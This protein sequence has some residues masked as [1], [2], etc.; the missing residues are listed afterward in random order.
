[1]NELMNST[2]RSEGARRRLLASVST[3]VLLVCADTMAQAGEDSHP[4]LWIELGGQLET[5]S[6][7]QDQFAPAFLADPPPLGPRPWSAAMGGFGT[8]THIDPGF[9]NPFEPVHPLSMQKPPNY[10]FGGEGKILLQPQ[11][12]DWVFAASVRY[13]RSNGHKSIQK[14]IPI[15]NYL[16]N[17]KYFETL[18]L[19]NDT[20]T[21][22][23]ESHGVLDFQVGRDV[24]LGLIGRKAHSTVNFGVRIA[25]LATK[26]DVRVDADP[27]MQAYKHV[28]GANYTKYDLR[29]QTYV[30]HGHSDRSFHGIGPSLS[31]NGSAP[32]IGNP[33]TMEFALDWGLNG[34]VLFGR[35]KADVSHHT[36]H[37]DRGGAQFGNGYR[38]NILIYN[39]IE[40]SDRA[41]SVIVP[42]VGAFAGLSAKFP[43][44]QV[45]FGY[46]ADFFFGAMDTGIDM[47]HTQ[48]MSFHGPFAKISIGLG[49]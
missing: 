19:F 39:N 21:T 28:N 40:T 26:S 33:D 22:Y 38:Q 49:G 41:R 14:G 18:A 11:G 24:G 45:S 9:P 44:A 15:Q 43:N 31:W 23:S 37:H 46:R 27:N 6:H 25:Q 16:P 48:D 3:A 12:S 4:I 8:G 42:N 20:Q 17:D 32:L 1:M 13:G 36:S 35:Q 34:A 47:R 29:F 7:T 2:V 30:L 10:A 5:L